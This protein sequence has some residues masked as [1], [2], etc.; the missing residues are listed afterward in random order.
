MVLGLFVINT[1]IYFCVC[2]KKCVQFVIC[3]KQGPKMKGVVLNRVL[4]I[5]GLFCPKQGQS[6][7]T[8]AQALHPDLGQVP[9]PPSH[10]LD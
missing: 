10:P 8:S 6:F 9:S 2:L 3:P 4:G 1:L 7:K 5:L